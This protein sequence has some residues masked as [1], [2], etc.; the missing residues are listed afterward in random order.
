MLWIFGKV[1]QQEAIRQVRERIRGNLLGIRLYRHDVR[2]V[3][4]LQSRIMWDTCV[5]LRYT[6]VPMLVLLIPV[7][8][9]LAQVNQ[10]FSLRPLAPGQTT[11]VKVT[12]QDGVLLDNQVT[13]HTPA[14]ILVETPAV[15]ILS[16]REIAWRIRAE[17]PGR[18]LLKVRAADTEV[19]KLVWVGA[20][21]GAVPALRMRYAGQ[22]LLYSSEQPI[23]PGTGIAAIKVLYPPLSLSL[24]GWQVHWLPLFLV[25]S[26]L[27][28]F[29]CKRFLGVEF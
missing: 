23:R 5:Y 17:R 7:M 9:I 28:G 19:N 29:A 20:G 12:L 13:L 24:F 3:L 2:V 8:L 27:V 10:R 18:Y 4:G 21:W 1:S 16:E 15:H 6:F 14:E 26:I 11:L 22:A 25:L